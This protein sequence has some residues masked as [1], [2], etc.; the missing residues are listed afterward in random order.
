MT[1]REVFCDATVEDPGR[2]WGVWGWV[3]KDWRFGVG[4]ER[5]DSKLH[6]GVLETAAAAEALKSCGAPLRIFS[7]NLGL[8][9]SVVNAREGLEVPDCYAGA[10]DLVSRD[11]SV[12]WVKGHSGHVW[13]E[14]VDW[15]VATGAD[16]FRAPPAGKA[17]RV[18]LMVS[19]VGDV[20]RWTVRS[21]S[22][23]FGVDGVRV[24][25][26]SK[27]GSA[28]VV[29]TG[30]LEA[31]TPSAGPV[32]LVLKTPFSN[33]FIKRMWRVWE[34]NGWRTSGGD[35]VPCRELWQRVADLDRAGVLET[36]RVLPR[37][38]F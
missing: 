29:L 24:E 20:G 37:S 3:T 35:P 2:R 15:L 16:E 11:V 28:V 7:D 14:T 38:G 19:L 6:I 4:V 21:G 32:E 30:L 17:R 1:V 9:G 5:S 18:Y 36:I 26:V 10:V 31:V 33:E 22:V 8:V 25:H 13:N 23:L 34:G 12:L 27:L